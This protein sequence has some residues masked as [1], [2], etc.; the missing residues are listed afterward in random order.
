M[1]RRCEL[2]GKGPMVGNNVSHANNKTKRR[3]LPNL[4]ETALMSET[5]GRTF[6]LKVSASALRT[7]GS[8]GRSGCLSSESQGRR[9]ERERLE[10][11][12][13][14]GEGASRLSFDPIG[15][16]G[17][18]FWRGFLFLEERAGA[19]PRQCGCVTVC[20]TS[21]P[22]CEWYVRSPARMLRFVQLGAGDFHFCTFLRSGVFP[23]PYRKDRCQPPMAEAC[24]LSK[25]SPVSTRRM[26]STRPARP[27]RDSISATL[28]AALA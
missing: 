17:P 12:E 16:Q 6:R 22:V 1:S 11:Q 4:T 5:L 28:A 25:S 27:I 10:N 13:R 8:P 2:T 7:V 26:R 9:I 20:Q 14:S 23:G 19:G 21:L 15:L 24:S 3:F 18:A